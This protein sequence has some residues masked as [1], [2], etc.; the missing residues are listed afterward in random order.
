[1]TA[2]TQTNL[3]VRRNGEMGRTGLDWNY[4]ERRVLWEC[5]VRSGGQR[6][7]G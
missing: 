1:M 4:L 3:P 5:C 7:D 6:S 2:A